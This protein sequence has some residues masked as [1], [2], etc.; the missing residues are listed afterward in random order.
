MSKI[1]DFEEAI[2]KLGFG[3]TLKCTLDARTEKIAGKIEEIEPKKEVHYTAPAIESLIQHAKD[4]EEY[5]VVS[6]RRLEIAPKEA[7]SESK[8]NAPKTPTTPKPKNDKPK[9][10]KVDTKDDES[11]DYKSDESGEGESSDNATA[12]T[13]NADGGDSPSGGPK[14]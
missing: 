1:K 13:A 2:A 3:E 12:Q 9:A 11:K 14:N 7:I 5:L 8:P 4:G 6:G 10:D